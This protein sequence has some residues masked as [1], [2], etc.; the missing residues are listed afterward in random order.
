[1]DDDR[2]GSNRVIRGG[3][4]RND[5]QNLRSAKRNNNDPGNR[6]DNVGFRLVSTANCQIGAVH[7]WHLRALGSVQIIIQRLAL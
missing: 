5:A 7:G 6:N 1:M 4:W 3:S 2:S